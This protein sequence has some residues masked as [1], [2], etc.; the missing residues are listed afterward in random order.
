MDYARIQLVVGFL[1][2]SC[3]ANMKL[4][5]VNGPNQDA[6]FKRL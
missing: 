1:I 2:G 4:H 3:L 5:K 6:H